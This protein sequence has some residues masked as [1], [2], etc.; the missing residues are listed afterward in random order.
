MC[1]GKFGSQN[2][3]ERVSGLELCLCS[4]LVSLKGEESLEK[5]PEGI[6]KNAAKCL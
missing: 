6:L 1:S 2:V 5:E 4:I 3:L